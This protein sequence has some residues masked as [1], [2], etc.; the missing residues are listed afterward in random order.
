MNGS[1]GE[2]RV[3][4]DPTGL[5]WKGRPVG[6]LWQ[7]SS[8]LGVSLPERKN[9]SENA[10]RD[11][12]GCKRP[13]SSGCA[14]VLVQRSTSGW[15]AVFPSGRGRSSIR[16]SGG[17]VKARQRSEASSPEHRERSDR[18]RS[19]VSEVRGSCGRSLSVTCYLRRFPSPAS[20][21]SAGRDAK[22]RESGVKR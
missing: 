16:A 13:N 5:L 14:L 9:P 22:V 21:F 20:R 17:W 8:S 10:I 1:P 19:G 11:V 2:S 3:T 4:D 18:P 12:T 7:A 6:T 15:G